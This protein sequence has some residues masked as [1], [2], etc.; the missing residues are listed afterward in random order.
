MLNEKVLEEN[1]KL[2]DNP[3]NLKSWTPIGSYNNFPF[4]G[5]FNGYEYTV[6]GI[7]INGNDNYLGLFGYLGEDG[8]I[9]NVGVVDGYIKGK[10][11]IGGVCGYNNGTITDCYNTGSVTA[12]SDNAGGVCG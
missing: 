12:T 2:I 7:Y 3:E 8:K 1:G 5:T 9:E 10:N 11:Y 4:S 6:K